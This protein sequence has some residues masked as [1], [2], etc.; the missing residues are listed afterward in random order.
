MSLFVLSYLC[1]GVALAA[2]TMAV[3]VLRLG[4][5]T[6]ATRLG[7]PLNYARTLWFI[8]TIITWPVGLY[9][10][11]TGR[12]V[13]PTKEHAPVSD[14]SPGRSTRPIS[15]NSMRSWCGLTSNGA[16]RIS[17]PDRRP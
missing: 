11:S 6:V 16:Q 13:L 17:T 7:M 2:G 15:P 10:L 14:L 5:K 3:P 12:L 8:G 9:V 1:F 4:M